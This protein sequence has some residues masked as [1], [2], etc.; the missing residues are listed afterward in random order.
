[1]PEPLQ[2]WHSARGP[3]TRSTAL[4]LLAT[5]V[6]ST[7]FEAACE[8]VSESIAHGIRDLDSLVSLHDRLTRHVGLCEPVQE[9]SRRIDAPQVTFSPDRYDQM[10]TGGSS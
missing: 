2:R 8:A 6:N 7:S 5:L 4:A 3:E 9:H 1:M 10:L